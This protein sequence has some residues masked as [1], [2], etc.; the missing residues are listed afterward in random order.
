MR[1]TLQTA[2][3]RN[4]AQKLPVQSRARYI[5]YFELAERWELALDALVELVGRA[6]TLFHTPSHTRSA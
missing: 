1:N 4:A 5:G 3:W 6:K 2:F